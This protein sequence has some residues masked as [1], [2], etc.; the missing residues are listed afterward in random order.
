LRHYK[1]PYYSNLAD[2]N[3]FSVWDKQG[4]TTMEARAV[5]MVDDIL[6][7]HTPEPLPAYIQSELKKII[8]RE[9][10]R[11]DTSSNSS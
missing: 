10:F 7:N 5:K 2:K 3:L 11:I 8:E 9:Q 1:E 6:A 4:A